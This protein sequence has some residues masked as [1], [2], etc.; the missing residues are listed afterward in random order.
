VRDLQP[1]GIWRRLGAGLVDGLLGVIIWIL[2]A[3][4]LV[5]AAWAFRGAP[6][7]L[8]EVALLGVVLAL[9]ERSRG[10]RPQRR[11]A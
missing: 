9:L 10:R 1:A 7:E 3:I 6:L 8:W 4:W 5:I 2:A 11:Q